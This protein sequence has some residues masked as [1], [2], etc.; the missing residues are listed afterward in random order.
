M[1]CDKVYKYE[2]DPASIV[3]DT[4]WTRFHPQ[5]EK[6]TDRKGETLGLGGGTIMVVNLFTGAYINELIYECIF[7]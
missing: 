6:L 4:K 5:T 7:M 3:E 2:M 1:L